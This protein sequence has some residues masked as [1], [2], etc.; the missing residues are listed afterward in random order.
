MKALV[1]SQDKLLL[2][3]V[4]VPEPG[5]G[6]VLVRV[7]L[8]GLCR[9]D[10]YVADGKLP[11]TF[12]R[13]LGHECSGVVCR[14]GHDVEQEM[15]GRRVAVFPWIGCQVCEFCRGDDE[16][17][18]YLCPH[19]KFLGWHLDGAFAEYIVVPHHRCVTLSET[20]S[21]QAGA[22][23]E[24]LV[25]ALAVLRAPLKQA[26][27]VAVVG[28]SRIANLTS[29]ILEHYAKCDHDRLGT[30]EGR[31]NSYDLIIE[32]AAEPQI[33]EHLVRLVRPD[34][35]L[36]LKS[37]PAE[38]IAWPLRLQVEKEITTM[39]LSYGSLKLAL[40]LLAR[41][42]DLFEDLWAEPVG[43]H[44]WKEVF[45]REREGEEETKLF[46]SPQAS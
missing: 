42:S 8:A 20:I 13:I 6:E 19:R 43:L 32:T 26:G 39:A 22:Y 25:A 11:T 21:F 9:T 37:R 7:S 38:P 33:V 28:R 34:G 29:R 45:A 2:A 15:L 17:L 24:P 10:V 23:L 12:P 41:K 18:G 36:V 16:K 1:K 44:E 40:L 14:L 31:D 3:N 4:A 27:R 30:G 35:M 46:F 5:A